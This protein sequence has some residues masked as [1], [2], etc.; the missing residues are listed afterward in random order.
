MAGCVLKIAVV[1]SFLRSNEEHTT[2]LSFFHSLGSQLE[3]KMNHAWSLSSFNLMWRHAGGCFLK[4]CLPVLVRLN[5]CNDCQRPE[6]PQAWEKRS[7][8]PRT[9][10]SI[11]NH[12]ILNHE[13]LLSSSLHL[14]TL[15]K[16]KSLSLKQFFSPLL[17]V[18]GSELQALF[19]PSFRTRFQQ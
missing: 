8:Q 11:A 3:S 2:E 1:S 12:H 18:P 17:A 5:V 9:Q 13:C 16:I 6:I 14:S 15:Q 10:P 4:S 19:L 7:F